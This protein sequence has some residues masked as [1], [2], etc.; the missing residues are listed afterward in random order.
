MNLIQI[1]INPVILRRVENH[2]FCKAPNEGYAIIKVD[3][4]FSVAG[5]VVGITF[6]NSK[7][8]VFDG[9]SLSVT[10]SSLSATEACAP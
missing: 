10:A 6:R 5:V 2:D 9:R 7:G 1:L 8:E 3:G 4:A